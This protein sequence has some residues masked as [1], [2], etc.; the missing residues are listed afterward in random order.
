MLSV[1]DSKTKEKIY[2]DVMEGQIAQ[3][4]SV[5]AFFLNGKPLRNARDDAEFENLILEGIQSIQ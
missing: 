2:R 4:Q 3:V 5:P 1:W